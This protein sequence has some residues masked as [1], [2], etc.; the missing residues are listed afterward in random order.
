[1]LSSALLMTAIRAA[2]AS[3]LRAMGRKLGFCPF[4]GYALRLE[5]YRTVVMLHSH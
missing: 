5:D 2:A 3:F 4:S 1:M